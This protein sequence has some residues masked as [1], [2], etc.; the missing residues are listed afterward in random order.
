M[1]TAIATE[2]HAHPGVFQVVPSVPTSHF[3]L[4]KLQPA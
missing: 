3:E 4:G 1:D 2:F